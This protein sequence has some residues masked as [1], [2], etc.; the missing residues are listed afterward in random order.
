MV[1]ERAFA[2]AAW[3]EDAMRNTGRAIVLLLATVV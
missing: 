2:K 1:S 3:K